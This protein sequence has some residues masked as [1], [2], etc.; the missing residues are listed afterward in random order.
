MPVR[1]GGAAGPRLMEIL[2]FPLRDIIIVVSGL[3]G[4]YLIVMMLR[5]L[6]VSR[7]GDSHAA[8]EPVAPTLGDQEETDDTEATDDYVYSR[9]L[10]SAAAAPAAAPNFDAEV[11]RTH[12]DREV[13]ML[14]EEVATL[15]NE[16]AQLKAAGRV[17]P[18]YAEAM[19]LAQRGLNAQ[20]VAD[21]CG[22]SLAEAELVWA[23]A[24]GPQ[25]FD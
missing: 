14:R 1:R 15:R 20:D 25:N 16:L 6:Q 19:A 21:R 9:P 22:I 11:V 13:K 12:L 5:L 7:H 10:A 23:L 8:V 3:V 2:G 4:V 17:S 24:R 18:Q